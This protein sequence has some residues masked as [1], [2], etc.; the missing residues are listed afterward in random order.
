MS[1]ETRIKMPIDIVNLMSRHKRKKQEHFFVITLTG[2]HEV[3]KVHLVTKGL[4]NKTL[5]HPR[6]VFYHA[7]KDLACAVV[8]VHNHPSS[9]YRASPEDLEI[10][11]RLLKASVIM[12]FHVIDHIIIGPKL[13]FHSFRE[14]H[15]VIFEKDYNPQE[16]SQYVAELKAENTAGGKP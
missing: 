11:E 15:D 2:A 1:K 16:L 7:V 8:F 5:V 6:E 13:G 4:V 12:G 14:N 3:I 10:I 9:E